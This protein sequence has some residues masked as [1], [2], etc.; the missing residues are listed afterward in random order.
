MAKLW[1]ERAAKGGGGPPGAQIAPESFDLVT[2]FCFGDFWARPGLDVR[3][4]GIVT[5]AQLAALGRTKELKAHLFGALNL[6]TSPEELIEVL[7]GPFRQLPR[8]HRAPKVGARKG[9]DARLYRGA[10]HPTGRES[11]NLEWIVPD[12]EVKPIVEAIRDGLDVFGDGD[13]EVVA[14]ALEDSV[15]LSPSVWARRLNEG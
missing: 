11:L 5:V 6:G 9:P 3:S 2:R 14:L 1:G 15:R 12:R 10:P 13:A 4:R 7:S 8:V